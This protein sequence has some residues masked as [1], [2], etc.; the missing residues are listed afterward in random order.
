MAKR[1]GKYVAGP[2][3]DPFNKIYG[4]EPHR[5]SLRVPES[6]FEKLCAAAEK[7]GVSV[8]DYLIRLI[9]ADMDNPP[10]PGP[11]AER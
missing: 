4:E 5:F 7:D 1:K 9:A 8:N 3:R 11:K 2:G 6:M 10:K